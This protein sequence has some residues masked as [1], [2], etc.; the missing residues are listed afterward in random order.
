MERPVLAIDFG[1]SYTAGASRIN[2]LDES[3]GS[4][5]YRCIPSLVFVG[6]DGRLTAGG[7]TEQLAEAFPGRVVH[8]PRHLLVTHD[9]VPVADREVPATALAAALLRHVMLDA[10]G[11]RGV[12][13]F[14][15][16]VL[17]YPARWGAE[18]VRA[19]GAAASEAGLPEPWFVT[20]AEAAAEFHDLRPGT[21]VA[22]YDLGGRS[23]DITVVRRTEQGTEIVGRPGGH[24]GFGGADLDQALLRIVAE[25][26]ARLDAAAWEELRGRRPELVRHE[27]IE[28]K[29]RLSEQDRTAVRLDGLPEAI[30]V[31]RAEFEDATDQMLRWSVGELLA[32]IERAGLSPADLAAVHLAGGATSM[33]RIAELIS[34]RLGRPPTTTADPKAV[35][36]TGALRAYARTA[37]SAAVQPAGLHPAPPAARRSGP[38]LMALAMIPV[39]AAV[40]A[41]SFFIRSQLGPSENTG[42]SSSI[43]PPPAEPVGSPA[44]SLPSP[45]DSATDTPTPTE[46]EISPTPEDEPGIKEGT[47]TVS[48]SGT[49]GGQTFQRTAQLQVTSTV[50]R[51]GTNNGVNPIEVCLRS[52][53]PAGTPEVGAIWFGTNTAC[54]PERGAQLDTATVEV[55]GDTVTVRPDAR[56]AAA[57]LNQFTAS[58]NYIYAC[59]YQPVSGTMTVTFS[60]ASASGELDINGYSGPCQAA[61]TN[62]TYTATFT[63]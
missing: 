25:R 62:T 10:A 2:D 38:R 58:G 29:H 22:V 19:L 63:N 9:S 14:D 50:A 47:Y 1:G 24:D 52:G 15:R 36:T 5:D 51:V 44:P 45:E 16:T 13:G 42:S 40:I 23:L 3:P 6:P 46:P 12:E 33:P 54:F 17:T 43:T 48:L 7:P 59:L 8:D 41:G 60:G 39:A 18:Q 53:F 49:V 55:S 31:T 28:A 21:S 56:I 34:E 61:G 57:G 30:T 35:F 4:V 20:E 26:A 32:A 11:Q 27:V 37:R